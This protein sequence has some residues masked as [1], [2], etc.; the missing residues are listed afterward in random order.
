[1]YVYIYM[2][3]CVSSAFLVNLLS[4]ESHMSS[5]MI[6]QHWL[7]NWLGAARQQAIAPANVNPDL[8]HH[9]VNRPQ[10]VIVFMIF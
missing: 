7:D 4:A 6:N 8:W 2:C 10:T 5:L 3:V 9:I 1:M